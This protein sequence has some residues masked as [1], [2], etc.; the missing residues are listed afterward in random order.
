MGAQT[1][2]LATDPARIRLFG[3]DWF[4]HYRSPY[5]SVFVNGRGPYTFLFDSGSNVTIFSTKVAKAASVAII[6]H[7]PGHHAIARAQ[8]LRVSGVLM[9]NYYAVIAD[10]N[11]VDG[12]LGFNSFGRDY[13]TFDF[14]SRTLLVSTHPVLLPLGFWMPY[15]LRKHLPLID[16]FTDGR[17][18]PTL[19]D[20]GDD[21]YGWEATSND[22]QGLLF[23]HLP[24]PSGTVFNGQTGATKTTITSVDGSLVL[25]RV[26]SDRPAI[27]INESLPLPDI[28]MS[29]IEQF[30]MEF[31]RIHRRV[32]FQPHFPGSEF[33]V[34][35]EIT[36]GFYLSFRQPVRRVRE[37]L[38][39]LAPERAGMRAGDVILSINGQRA[40]SV[41]YQYWD[42]L[43]QARRLVAVAWD[44]EGQILSRAFPVLELK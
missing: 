28:G 27:A 29:V 2:H 19:I 9:H 36:C 25:G 38:P 1:A 14:S 16:L 3:T 26:H 30:V 17:A 23:D 43:L 12:I 33:V 22:L 37:V 32:A 8:E 18:L 21:A 44:H 20:T 39:G 13:L 7:V 15:T 34:H 40:A 35:G 41:N 5:V 31:D 42:R 24:V 11:D 4:G 6:N 10:G